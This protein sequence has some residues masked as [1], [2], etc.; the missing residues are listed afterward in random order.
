M[1]VK[2]RWTLVATI[3]VAAA[4]AAIIALSI[5]DDEPTY[6]NRIL[7]EWVKAYADAYEIAFKANKPEIASSSEAAQALREMTPTAL[8]TLI[9]W[10]RYEKPASVDYIQRFVSRTI[11]SD[12]KLVTLM[13]KKEN[14]TWQALGVFE[15]LGTN[16]A[17]AIPQLSNMVLNAKHPDAALNALQAMSSTGKA[18]TQTML[19]L[20]HNPTN[21]RRRATLVTLR[22]CYIAD[23]DVH[24]RE[25]IAQEIRNCLNDPD[26]TI[27]RA[28]TNILSRMQ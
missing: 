25:L 12:N 8:P 23:P 27:R 2:R 16:A 14:R 18:G 1:S 22:L 3:L 4:V 11:G 26:V 15:I 9:Q 13:G 10:I 20:F 24:D 19:A 28:A 6:K 17:P 7:S 21:P 5:P